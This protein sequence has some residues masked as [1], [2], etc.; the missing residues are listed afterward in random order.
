MRFDVHL[1]SLLAVAAALVAFGGQRSPEGTGDADA[2]ETDVAI[3]PHADDRPAEAENDRA[4]VPGDEL[5]PAPAASAAAGRA[6]DPG[7]DPGDDDDGDEEGDDGTS[8][9]ATST[10]ATPGALLADAPDGGK[11]KLP[12]GGC[13]STMVRASTYCIDRYEAPNRR[14]AHPLV[15]QSANDANAWCT[16]HDKRMCT[17]D[18]WIGA[19][20][21]PEHRAYPYGNEHV[22]SRCNDDKI[23]Q[24]VD[25]GL[26]AKWPSPEAKAHAKEVYQATPSGSKRKCTSEYGARDLTGNVEEW[27]VRTREHANAWPYILIGCYWSGCYGGNKPTCHSTNNAHGPDFRFYETGFRCC[28]DLAPGH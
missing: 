2:V 12:R 18:E 20:Q 28:K 3:A 15:M 4:A 27:V 17:E 7:D 5:L 8:A 23:W 16:E 25:E 19:C 11:R 13:P 1:V 24:K 14:G 22:D 6:P 26:L 9:G 21:G 10:G